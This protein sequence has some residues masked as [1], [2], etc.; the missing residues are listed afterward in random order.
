MAG[1]GMMTKR[2]LTN[3]SFSLARQSHT[4]TGSHEVPTGTVVARQP[5]GA[6]TR[7]SKQWTATFSPRPPSTTARRRMDIQGSLASS[8]P[9]LTRAEG[10]WFEDCGLII[11]A[12]TTLFRVSRDFLAM[13]SVVFRDMLAMPPPA[14]TEMMEGC[15]FVRLP[16][17]ADDFDFFLRALLYAEFLEPHPAKTT[18]PIIAGV[19]RMSHKYEVE[20][21]RKRA[22]TQLSSRYPTRL[23]SSHCLDSILLGRQIDAPWILPCAF[24]ELCN[25]MSLERIITGHLPPADMVTCVTGLRALETSG[26]CQVL[27]FLDAAKAKDCKSLEGCQ[28]LIGATR[29]DMNRLRTHIRGVQD[30]YLPLEI[31]TSEDWHGLHVCAMC[32]VHL[33]AVHKGSMDSFWARL[34]EI[35]NLPPWAELEQ[36]R[37]DALE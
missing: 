14:D 23:G 22:L 31:W 18:F 5:T 35:F 2:M 32:L 24:Y 29:R 12:E 10:L 30:P 28:K 36:M 19:L 8:E 13:R 7:I 16:D 6:L 17:R 26:L 1:F 11:Q 25:G 20:P 33:Q 27:K 4:Q 34:P 21:L 9:E 15:P 37:T 3:R